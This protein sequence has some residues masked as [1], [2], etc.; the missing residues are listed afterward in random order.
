MNFRANASS[1]LGRQATAIRHEFVIGP[2][3]KRSAFQQKARLY[4]CIR[5]KWSFL[6]C[7]SKVAVLHEDGGALGR[8]E[9]LHRFAT[10]EEGPCPVLEAF[11]SAASL[12]TGPSEPHFR[13]GCDE[14]VHL[15]SRRVRLRS[16]RPR[17]VLHVVSQVRED[18]A[19]GGALSNCLS[20]LGSAID[21]RRL[22]AR[23][24][25]GWFW[26]TSTSTRRG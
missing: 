17:P 11:R 9:G 13:R 2:L 23:V 25:P 10:F 18:L 7:G 4:Y 19:R 20:A 16:E 12:N 5:C 1:G 26:R 15:V 8:D 3:R 6:V 21:I 24:Q 22:T 14:R